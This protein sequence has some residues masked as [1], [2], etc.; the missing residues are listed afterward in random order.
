MYNVMCVGAGRNKV[1]APCVW[2]AQSRPQMC[3]SPP[4]MLIPVLWIRDILVQ[5]QIRG[6]VSLTSGSGSCDV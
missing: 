1:A 6:S 5:I 2:P 3:D 4:G